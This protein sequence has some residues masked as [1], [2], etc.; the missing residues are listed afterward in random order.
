M[1][2]KERKY[3][4]GALLIS[5]GIL[6]GFLPMTN[7]RALELDMTEALVDLLGHTSF[8][9]AGSHENYNHLLLWD[10]GSEVNVFVDQDV[11]GISP[12][13]VVKNIAEIMAI[14]RSNA[15][16]RFNVIANPYDAQIVIVSSKNKN[17][18]K[19]KSF[20]DF[21]HKKYGTTRGDFRQ[22]MDH[23]D[24]LYSTP[25]FARIVWPQIVEDRKTG[26]KG[27]TGL[28]AVVEPK[29]ETFKRFFSKIIFLSMGYGNG[30]FMRSRLLSVQTLANY[31][32]DG[33]EGIDFLIM[34]YLYNSQARNG[35]AKASALKLFRRW[36]KS[37]EFNNLN[38]EFM[39][40]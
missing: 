20:Y 1:V 14:F 15:S 3:G 5:V 40:Y 36:L 13:W 7:T 2:C 33:I 23:I 28:L 16:I 30:S 21:L 26:K 12:A 24:Q 22:F 9:A 35:M 10:Y 8:D 6:L 19:S 17:G 11:D 25:E 32:T 34:Y 29:T 37:E 39:K 31:K 4:L 27:I 38:L 18:L